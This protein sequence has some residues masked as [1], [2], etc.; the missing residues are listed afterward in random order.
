[1]QDN[2]VDQWTDGQ[3][4]AGGVGLYYENGESAKLRDTLN[5]IPLTRK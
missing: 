3:L 1:V 4:A 2:K 5:V